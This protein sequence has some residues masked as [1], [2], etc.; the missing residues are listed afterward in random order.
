[1]ELVTDGRTGV[2]SVRIA[3]YT[4]AFS[5]CPRTKLLDQLAAKGIEGVELPS[6]GF[7]GSPHCPTRELL[8]DGDARQKLLEDVG[9]RGLA[10][11]AL[12]ANGNPL[13]PNAR[14]GPAHAQD[15]RD[16]IELAALL[17]VSC[18]VA[19]PGLPGADSAASA[20][21]WPVHPWES[22][23]LDVVDWQFDAVA[24]PFWHSIGQWA[25]DRGVRVAL[26]MH[27]HTVAYNPYTLT[28]LLDGAG[29]NSLG[30][31]LDPSHLF[32]QG[33]DP[34]LA[35]ETLGE[36]VF[37]AAA[38]D[39]FLDAHALKLHGVLD[40]RYRRP[41]RDTPGYDLGGGYLLTEPVVDC[42][43]RF[44]TV[45]RGHGVSFWS[46]FLAAL[47]DFGDV[48]AIAIEHGDAEVQPELGVAEAARVLH[49][50][51]MTITG[52]P[53]MADTAL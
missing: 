19:M 7:V 22:G 45:G 8:R 39:T 53:L 3:C 34:C 49:E 20:T 48:D 18:V 11:V 25:E 10:I 52:R 50:A 30:A 37:H 26:E 6:G 2:R 21:T 42:A 35:V 16:S 29:G 36:R 15:L 1:V 23:V 12:N 33:I 32:W 27:P 14:V 41:G 9:S 31:N 44:V 24:I 47:C 4:A 13:H 38:K 43:W 28:R 40:G 5:G 51:R 17:G 46:A